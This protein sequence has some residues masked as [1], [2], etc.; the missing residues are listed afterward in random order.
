M[1]KSVSN[2]KGFAALSIFLFTITC[3]SAQQNDYYLFLDSA[4]IIGKISDD[5][6]YTSETEI[7]YNLQ[8]KVIYKGDGTN[9]EQIFLIAD[10]KDFFSKKTGIIYQANSK[11]VQYICQNG[12]LYLGDYPINKYYERL[13]FMEKENDSLI[14]VY[15]GISEAIIGTIEG[16]NISSTQLIAASHLYVKHFDLQ[17]EIEKIVAEKIETAETT[18]GGTIKPRYG[19]NIY[20][21]WVW[22]GNVLRPAWGNRPEDEWKFDGKYLQSGWSLDPQS[23]WTWD[24]SILKP[25]WDVTAKNQWTWEGNVLRPFWDSNPDK[26]YIL[27]D[28]IIRPR[29][30]YE[31][32]Y[33][34][35]IEGNIPLPI[36]ALVVLG[37]ADR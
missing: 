23:E 19:N 16:K 33:Q 11:T 15:H 13:L 2:I 31:A 35:E 17:Q 26:T 22:D 29:W 8:G 12:E 25:S 21:E 37:I 20:F 27:E 7:A 9:K 14:E 1:K 24:G 3:V 18:P 30:S 4:T 32:A 6:I 34:W 5:K 36:I 28:N 10:V